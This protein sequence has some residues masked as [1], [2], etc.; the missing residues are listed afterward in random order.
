MR[1][2]A[3]ILRRR[4]VV[5]DRVNAGLAAKSLPTRIKLTGKQSY[6]DTK[7]LGDETEYRK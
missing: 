1:G 4:T 7:T 5:K 6:T 2:E 3:G